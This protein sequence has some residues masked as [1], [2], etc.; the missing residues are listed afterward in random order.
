MIPLGKP[1]AKS[2]F[3]SWHELF[4][5]ILI[6][7]V[8]PMDPDTEIY[9]ALRIQQVVLDELRNFRKKLALVRAAQVA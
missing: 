4:V 9:D 7:R 1:T 8:L 3:H 6:R 2:F 5:Q